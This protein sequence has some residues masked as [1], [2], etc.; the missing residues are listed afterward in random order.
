M[1]KRSHKVLKYLVFYGAAVLLNIMLNKLVN[2]LGLPIFM[3]SVGTITAG[4]VGGYLPGIIVGYLTNIINMY[5]ETANS[6]YAV[7]NAMLAILAAYLAEKGFFRSFLSSVRTIPLF[8]LVGGAVSSVLTYLIYGFGIGEGISAPFAKT[9]LDEGIFNVFW[10]QFISDI[11]LDIIDKAITVTIVFVLI[12]LL[13]GK[14]KKDIIPTFW[15]QTPLSKTEQNEAT[16]NSAHRFS[17][18]K[19]IIILILPFQLGCSRSLPKPP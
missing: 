8:A 3:D 11:A 5:A 7:I 2:L 14:I 15:R 16:Q 4:A 1:G 9:L 19:K 6:Y 13:P 10:A 18:R 12:R 17:L